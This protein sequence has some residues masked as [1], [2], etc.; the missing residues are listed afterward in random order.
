MSPS[1]ARLGLRLRV[2]V[3]V[4]VRVRVGVRI[5]IRIRVRV[6]RTLRDPAPT[7]FG[8]TAD[9]D[10][11]DP[12]FPRRFVPRAFDAILRNKAHELLPTFTATA[13][14]WLGSG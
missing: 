11:V 9:E 6:S 13:Q 5:R 10:L 4:G 3:G 12:S 2:R 14:A 1:G 7:R 8:T